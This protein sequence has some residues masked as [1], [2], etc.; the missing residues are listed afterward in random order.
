MPGDPEH[1]AAAIVADHHLPV[2][3]ERGE[4]STTGT[5]DAILALIALSEAGSLA[6]AAIPACVSPLSFRPCIY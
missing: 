6:A 4:A 2:T 3:A 5:S 1:V